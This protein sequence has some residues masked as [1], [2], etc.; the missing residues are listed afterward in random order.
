[1]KKNILLIPLIIITSTIKAQNF[2]WAKQ[3]S[4]SGVVSGASIITDA[5]GNVYTTGY[6]SGTADFDPGPSN[7][8]L[9]SSGSNDIFI[10]KLDAAGNFVWA[11]NIGGTGNDV[12]YSIAIDVSGNVYTTGNFFGTVD[13]DPGAGTFNLTSAGNADIF[14]SKLNAAGD[15][16]WAKGMGGTGTDQVLSIIIDALGNVIT[17]GF[18]Q[19]TADFDPGAG[20]FNLTSAGSWDIFISKLNGAGDFVWAKRMGGT[21][22]DVS[23]S[24]TIDA[25]GNVYTTGSFD[26]TADFDPGGGSFILTSFGLSDIFISK[27]DASG[28]FIWTKRMGGSSRDQSNSIAI[29]ASGNVYTTGYFKGTADFDPGGNT[30]DLTSAGGTDIFI[31]KLDASGNF[32]WVNGMGST[33]DDHGVS[34]KA[35]NSGNTYTDGGFSSTV[36]FDPGAGI[37]NLTS[38]GGKDIFISKL[39]ASGNFIWANQFGNTFDD[40]AASLFVDADNSFYITGNFDGTVDFNPGPGVFEMTNA[41]LKDAYMLKMNEAAT[42][43]LISSAASGNWSNPATWV[44]GVVP[45]ATDQVIIAADNDIIMDVSGAA[46][47]LIIETG[48]TT[49]TNGSLS[50]NTAGVV[51]TIGEFNTGGGKDSV[52]VKGALNISNG[53]LN[54]GGRLLQYLSPSEI[55][56]TGGVIR[57]DGNTGV[58]GTS[59]A[60]ADYL[61]HSLATNSANYSFTGGQLVFIDPPIGA[62]GNTMSWDVSGGK[63]LGTNSEIVFG[64][65]V[66]TTAGG[67][68]F[69]LVAAAC[70]DIVVN[71]P[72]GTNRSVTN[73]CGQI[74]ELT[75]TAGLFTTT[76]SLN[77]LGA[78]VNNG[79]L[80]CTATSMDMQGGCTN[81]GTITASNDLLAN[82]NV[83][84]NAGASITT[85]NFYFTKNLTNNGTVNASATFSC[86]RTN[87][88]ASAFSQVISGSGAFN[89]GAA[90]LRI[91]NTNAA[92]VTVNSDLSVS[93][94][95][96]AEGKFYLGTNNITFNSL[97]VNG[98]DADSYIVTNGTGR[99]RFTNLTTSEVLFPIGTAT[100][101]NPVKIN[102]GSGHTFSTGVQTGF[103]TAPP[104]TDHVNREWD[105]DDITG[106]AVS[107]DVTLQWNTAD[108]GVSFNRN[109]CAVAHYNGSAWHS[110]TAAGVAA[111]PSAGVYTRTANGVTSFSPFSVS[112]NLVVLPLNLIY[113]KAIKEN[114]RVRISW[115][116]ESENG[117]SHFELQRSND[118]V[119]YTSYQTVAA[120]NTMGRHNYSVVDAMPLKG[121]N[122]YRLRI[123]DRNEQFKLSQ[124]V[125]VNFNR[126]IT[127]TISP[128][129]VRDEIFIQSDRIITGISLIDM[130]GR[131]VKQFTPVSGNRYP[132]QYLSPGVYF[133][134]VRSGDL[135]EVQQLIKE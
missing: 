99:L 98:G 17:S 47:T 79:T 134:M 81:N 13:F 100:T 51:L 54:I 56:H 57:I 60:D 127:I 74:Q 124:I 112:S 73:S 125:K 2:E 18:F 111:N 6:F 104:G 31:S 77:I 23:Y 132:V 29:D 22:N 119:H 70:G 53:A 75:I 65:G 24:A 20:A 84:N 96:L 117:V 82:D 91:D 110:L 115:Q 37:F 66:S 11:K 42:P 69:K 25:S 10:S 105:I 101:Y 46:K 116:T 83:T 41:G 108:E 103:T 113:F 126:D 76:S 135:L 128:N 30:V 62:T 109:A 61:L 16:V 97:P 44:G 121:V 28:N 38:A 58:T 55:N 21:G 106:G 87:S 130:S 90:T 35:D 3:F 14:I 95:A 36:D 114:N 93:K 68:G 49:A 120:S 7:V 33:L 85:P 8:S 48:G 71:N 12:S 94:L 63:I 32:V 26:G 118:G 78:T 67:S 64:D 86:S 59:V 133:V 131:I 34:I 122:Y 43:P 107:A 52:V 9:T 27:H 5:S 89:L 45:T 72:S 39:D 123:V 80:S 88:T 129:P 92:G 19:G 4:S 1:M 50:M 15:F 40:Y 102:N